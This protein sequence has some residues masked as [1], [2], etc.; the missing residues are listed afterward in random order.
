MN[1]RIESASAEPIDVTLIAAIDP[2]GTPPSFQV[3]LSTVTTPTGSWSNGS[4]LTAWDTSGR[5][6]ARTPT[7]GAA[8]TLVVV[9]GGEYTLWVKWGTVVK[10]AGTITVD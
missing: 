4:W 9:E 3:T 8:G 1:V 10:R 5:L 6:T 7:V 2:T